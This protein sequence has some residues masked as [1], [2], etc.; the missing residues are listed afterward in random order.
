MALFTALL[1]LLS[2]LLHPAASASPTTHARRVHLMDTGGMPVGSE[3][4]DTGGM[5]VGSQPPDGGGSG[6]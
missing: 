1:L 6:D 2:S 5:P 4:S 3:P